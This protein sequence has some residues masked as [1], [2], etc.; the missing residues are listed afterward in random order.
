M[1]WLKFWKGKKGKELKKPK[2]KKELTKLEKFQENI[3]KAEKLVRYCKDNNLETKQDW[4]D[5]NVPV[6]A[7][8]KELLKSG[9]K[10]YDDEF[11]KN[12][13]SY[14]DEYK[15]IINDRDL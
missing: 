4:K 5:N 9:I 11:K 3:V 12:V 14:G 10:A 8:S 13:H 6:V 15:E 7:L 1:K 2:Q